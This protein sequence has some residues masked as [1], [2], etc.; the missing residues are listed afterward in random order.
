[1]FVDDPRASKHIQ[2][3]SKKVII[4]APA[5]GADILIASCTTSCLAPFVKILDE[6]F[7]IV[8]GTMTTTHS[9]TGDQAQY[10]S[11]TTLLNPTLPYLQYMCSKWMYLVRMFFDV[12][13]R[14]INI[15]L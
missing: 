10:L 15:S 4:T 6:E 11:T 9:Y 5:K 1:M 13:M 3:S 12:S 14:R 7:G 2:A 8:K